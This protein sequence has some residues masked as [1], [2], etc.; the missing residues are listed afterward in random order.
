MGKKG[1]SAE[2]KIADQVP[3]QKRKKHSSGRKVVS[4]KNETLVSFRLI[5]R[6]QKKEVDRTQKESLPRKKKTS[7]RGGIRGREKLRRGPRSFETTG[8]CRIKKNPKAER[9]CLGKRHWRS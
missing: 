5:E 6:F 3:F 1:A 4:K 8:L 2:E 9:D 7:T